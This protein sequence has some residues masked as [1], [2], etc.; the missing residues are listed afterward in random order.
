MPKLKF[1]QL[2]KETWKDF[3]TLFG[4][5]GACGGCWCMHWRLTSSQF[6]KLKGEGNKKAMKKLVDKNTTIGIIAYDGKIPIGWC[7]VAPREDFIRLG[8]SKVLKPV[9]DKPVWSI[10][11]FFINKEYRKQ[12]LSSE[13]I[14]GAVEFCKKLSKAKSRSAGKKAQIVEGYPVEPYTENMPAAFAWTGF[15]NAFIKAG[16]EEVTRRS[17]TRP[18]M[19]Y[20]L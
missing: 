16:F 13:I 15:P 14:K 12:G 8:N 11:C 1:K 19:R 9:D 7:S 20:Y 17:K 2:K 5:R 10:V 6:D 18:I 4:E 3:T